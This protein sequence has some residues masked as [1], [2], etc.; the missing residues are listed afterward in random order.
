[1]Q[2]IIDTAVIAGLETSQKLLLGKRIFHLQITGVIN[3]RSLREDLVNLFGKCL[4]IAF[5]RAQVISGITLGLTCIIQT[6]PFIKGTAKEGIVSTRGILMKKCLK[7]SQV[8]L[9]TFVLGNHIGRNTLAGSVR[10]QS[11]EQVSR[12]GSANCLEKLLAV[13]WAGLSKLLNVFFIV[14]LDLG[15]LARHI[16][17][18]I[19]KI[20]GQTN[21]GRGDS[22]IALLA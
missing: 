1:M 5:A 13:I 10:K 3:R 11:L 15:L 9:V 2:L 12:V 19:L 16:A 21:D 17:K 4:V 18:D 6:C 8:L 22:F 7:Q 14:Q 20:S